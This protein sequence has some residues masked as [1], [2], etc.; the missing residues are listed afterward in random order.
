MSAMLRRFVIGGW[1]VPLALC[2]LA[3]CKVPPLSVH[4]S[5]RVT[6]EIP[7]VQAFGPVMRMTLPREPDLEA[8]RVAIIDVDGLLLNTDMTG[9]SSLGENP[10]ALFRERLD[11]AADD[12]L[13]CAIVVRINSPGG[14]V[15]ACDVMRRDLQTFRQ[16]TGRPVVACL[17]DLGAGGAYYLATAADTIVAHPTTVTGGIGVILNLYNLQD[18]MNQFNVLGVPIRAGENIDLGSPIREIPEEGRAIL[19][20]M[21]NEFHD[22]FKQSVAGARP[23]INLKDGELFDGR[24]FTAQQALERRLVDSIGYVDDAVSLAGQLAGQLCTPQVVFFH[25]CNDRARSVHAITP[26][27]PLQT[28]F[29]PLSVPGL[30]RSRLPTFLYLWQP[31]P[32]LEKWA[33]H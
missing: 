21:A 29:L 32:A 5:G 11:A 12:P 19:Q 1:L 26:N 25:R 9:L 13:V 33:G 15:T 17:M 3:G 22:R 8:P 31:D 4:T 24:V 10:V 14:G 16:R 7:P 20:Q 6:A 30:D 2:L 23:T 27:V 28:A 18:T